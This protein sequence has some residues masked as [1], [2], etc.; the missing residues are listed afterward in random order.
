M[1]RRRTPDARVVAAT[2]QCASLLLDY[3]GAVDL[4]P[5]AR[6]VPELPATFAEPSQTPMDSSRF[7]RF[8]REFMK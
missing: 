7:R 1:R 3:P 2:W 5:V 6:T 8:R 4:D